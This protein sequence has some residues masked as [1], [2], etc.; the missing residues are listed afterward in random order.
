MR[1]LTVVYGVGTASERKALGMLSPRLLS[2]LTALACAVSLVAGCEA[3]NGDDTP[4]GDPSAS[5]GGT[6]GLKPA[7]AGLVVTERPTLAT[8]PYAEFGTITTTW[9]DVEPSEGFFDFSAV[10]EVLDAHPDIRFRLRIRTGREAPYWLKQATDGCLTVHP[11]TENGATGCVARYWHESFL[12]HFSVLMEEVARRY[13]DDG[14]VVDVAN[15]A[16]STAYAEP[17]ILGVDAASLELLEG[18]GLTPENHRD[19]IVGSTASMMSSFTRTRVSLAGHG[20]WEFTDGRS[21]E[22]ERELLN[23][24]RADYPGRLVLEDHGL[25]PDDEVC[26]VPGEPAET[27]ESWHCYL[28]GLPPDETPHGWQLTLNDGSMSTAVQAGVEMGACYLEYAAFQQLSDDE[29]QEVHDALVG[30][31]PPSD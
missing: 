30:N 19:C 10:D 31:C 14:Q 13:E 1:L 20:A 6:S 12:D 16:C 26:P 4:D 25:G 5:D 7:L 9:S 2:G 21:W 27:A 28:A 17:F 8:V 24:L 15:S 23:E 22:A 11:S 29:R 18:A 3:S